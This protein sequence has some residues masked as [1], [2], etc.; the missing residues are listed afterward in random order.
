MYSDRIDASGERSIGS[1]MV[2]SSGANTM[3]SVS[4]DTTHRRKWIFLALFIFLFLVL[5]YGGMYIEHHAEIG[6]F[7][8]ISLVLFVAY[9]FL[10]VALPAAAVV[11]LFRRQFE[12][13]IWL[14]L[15]S[16]FVIASLL[17]GR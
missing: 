4:T 15:I 3:R 6:A 8:I 14:L 1:M 13:S 17:F 12:K 2:P 11:F 5:F 10:C 7:S 9:L 16:A